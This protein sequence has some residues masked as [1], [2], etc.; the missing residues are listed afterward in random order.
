MAFESF[1]KALIEEEI[2]M[3]EKKIMSRDGCLV[4]DWETVFPGWACDF[5]SC[6]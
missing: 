4:S 3:G 5:L 1:A 6:L 2:N